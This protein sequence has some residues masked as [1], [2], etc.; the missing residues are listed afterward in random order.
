M[1]A[2][3]T[4]AATDMILD[5]VTDIPNISKKSAKT[6]KFTAVVIPPVMM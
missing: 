1:Y 6:A 3:I 4:A 5:A 2:N